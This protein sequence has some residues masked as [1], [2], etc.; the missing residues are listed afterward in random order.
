MANRKYS[1]ET[2]LKAIR[3][4]HGI[5]TDIAKRLKISRSTFDSWLKDEIIKKA[6]DQELESNLDM[7]ENALFELIK[8]G[9]TTALI[10]YLK[11]KGKHR[12]YSE[13]FTAKDIE[14]VNINIIGMT[15]NAI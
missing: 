2:I 9:N 5:K 7:A 3:G 6:Y 4:S 8:S 11:T 10:Y 1:N 14:R 15:E 12:G 13:N